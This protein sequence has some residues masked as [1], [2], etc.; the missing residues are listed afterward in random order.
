MTKKK[1]G[2]SITLTP[3][4][5]TWLTVAYKT[6]MPIKEMASY[7]KMHTDTVKRLLVLHDIAPHLTTKNIAA[8]QSTYVMWE[9]P[10]MSC[11]D[12]TP[13]PKNQYV[14]DK[15]RTTYTK[16]NATDDFLYH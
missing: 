14:C 10:C 16:E 5:L 12:T 3:D 13:R 4:Q 2:H 6:F 8:K 1:K 9:R 15:C 7:L 11:K